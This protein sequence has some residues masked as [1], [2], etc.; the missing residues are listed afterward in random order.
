MDRHAL[1]HDLY[2]VG[3][4]VEGPVASETFKARIRGILKRWQA[5]PHGMTKAILSQGVASH[6]ISSCMIR[7]QAD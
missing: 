6:V 3:D 2:S 7:P 5:R 4:V 1:K